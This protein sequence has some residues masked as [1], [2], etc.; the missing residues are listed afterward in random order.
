MGSF[1]APVVIGMDPGISGAI[2]ILSPNGDLIQVHDMPVFVTTKKVAGKTK[3]KSRIN[4]HELGAILK[5]YSGARAVIERVSPRPGEGTVSSF[6]FGTA[7]GAL[8]GA[9][10][11]LDMRIEEPTPAQWKKHFRLSADKNAARQA[12]T[13]RWPEQAS[14][15]KRVMDAGRA[16]A[17]LI[18]LYAIETGAGMAQEPRL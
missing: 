9:A 17:C 8:H 3:N 6:T 7:S 16:E 4:V 15:F 1:L 10:G 18:A 2:G 14:M 13:R 11:A 12:A 5:G